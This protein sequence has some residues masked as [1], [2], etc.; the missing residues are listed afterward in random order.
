MSRYR[1]PRLHIIRRL[2][3]LPGFTSKS[4]NIKHVRGKPILNIIKKKKNSDYSLR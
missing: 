4:I 1:G 3:K 2:D